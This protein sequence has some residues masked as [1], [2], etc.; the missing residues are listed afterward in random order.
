VFFAPLHEPS[1]DSSVSRTCPHR[2]STSVSIFREFGRG[3]A[4]PLFGTETVRS[5]CSAENQK[6]RRSVYL[7]LY[8][9]AIETFFLDMRFEAVVDNQSVS[10]RDEMKVGVGGEAFRDADGVAM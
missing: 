9:P 2:L 1:D 4:T 6:D 3:P 7:Y 10:N 8:S 5:F